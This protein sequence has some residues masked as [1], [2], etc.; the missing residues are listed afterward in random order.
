MTKNVSLDDGKITSFKQLRDLFN[1][2]PLTTNQQKLNSQKKK[3]ES[4][5]VCKE[6]GQVLTWIPN[7]NVCTCT[8]PQCLGIKYVTLKT[9]DKGE[10][11]EEVKYNVSYHTLNDYNTH[12]A[13][14]LYSNNK[15]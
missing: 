4:R 9:N 6:C 11:V 3:F 10:E 14:K 13:E 8:N 5:H 2:P 1:L 15:S 7:T 12:L